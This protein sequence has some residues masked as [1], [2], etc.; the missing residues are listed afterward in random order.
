MKI[1]SLLILLVM[2][3]IPIMGDDYTWSKVETNLFYSYMALSVIDV[4]QTNYG[5]KMEYFEQAPL[6]GKHPSAMKVNIFKIVMVGA[7]YIFADYVPVYVPRVYR[8]WA[9][10]G[11]NI[12]QIG[13]VTS[14]GLRSG[15][16]INM[17]F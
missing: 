12:I 6:I 5:L 2:I 13:V 7:I 3:S 1:L 11:F 15:V 4:G 8:E 17:A 14:N 16:G 10:W 9:L